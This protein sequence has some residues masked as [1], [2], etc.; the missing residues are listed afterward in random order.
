[1]AAAIPA[2]VQAGTSIFSGIFG[3]SAAKKAAEAQRQAAIAA[4]NKI[5]QTASDVNPWLS[6]TAATAGG[7]VSGQAGIAADRAIATAGAG[8]DSVMGAIGDANGVLD[9][10]ITTGQNATAT[11]GSML[12]QGGELTRSFSAADM[13]A[14]DPGY[15]FRLDQSAKAANRALAARGVNGGGVGKAMGDYLGNLASSEYGAA[16]DRFQ[17]QQAQKYAMLS[18]VAGMGLNAGTTA[19]G[20]IMQGTEFGANLGMQ[21]ADAASRYGMAGAQYSGDMAMRATEDQANNFMHAAGQAGEYMLQAGNAQAA[22][23]MGSA[24][25]WSSALSGI[26]QAANTWGTLKTLGNMGGVQN[27]PIP[28]GYTGYGNGYGVRP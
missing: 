11:L 3:S 24:N 21:G 2:L 12:G 27:M 15:Q 22:G 7:M 28:P 19:G 14:N 1:M 16:F 9:P 25:A 4:A 20:N 18:G 26:G 6:N 13:E 5:Q 8:K 10:W 23:T 17:K